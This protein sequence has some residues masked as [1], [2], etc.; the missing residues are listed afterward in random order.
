MT[1]NTAPWSDTIKKEARG[2][3]D[4][5]LG[6]VQ[7]T[8]TYYVH[9]QRGIEH[10][11]QFYIP[12]KLF[13]NYDGH[14]VHFDVDEADANQFIGK[15]YPSDE[16][17]RA[18]YEPQPKETPAIIPGMIPGNPI[19]THS[20]NNSISEQQSNPINMQS[21]A[22]SDVVERIPLM[23]EHLDVTKHVHEDEVSITKIP[24]KET[25]TKDIEV[26]HDEI[27]V[28]EVQPSSSTKIPEMKKGLTE[29]TIRIPVEHE[30]VDIVKRPEVRE[31]LIIHKTPI[32][33]TRHISEDIQSEK[34]QISDKTKDT[35]LEEEK[36]KPSTT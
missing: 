7:D 8:G 21:G 16:E 9:T 25:Q 30:D 33:E 23:T 10:R 20:S 36:K 17:Y 5:D 11:T 32:T 24:Y 22:S 18:K 31:E 26:T 4:Y 14:T 15:K 13:K 35:A 6:E 28:E 29:E 2:T 12:K 3:N 19:N 34:F 27:R 1:T